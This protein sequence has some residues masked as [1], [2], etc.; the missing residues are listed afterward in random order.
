MGEIIPADYK[1]NLKGPLVIG[2]LCYACTLLVFDKVIMDSYLFMKYESVCFYLFA[3]Y[4]LEY[5]PCLD[6][7]YLENYQQVLCGIIAS[8]SAAAIFAGEWK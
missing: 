7:Q 2:N 4:H 5:S 8:I 1:V 3:F 6:N